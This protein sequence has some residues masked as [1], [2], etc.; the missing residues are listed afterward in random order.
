VNSGRKHRAEMVSAGRRTNPFRIR[1]LLLLMRFIQV[2]G[3]ESYYSAGEYEL[4][5]AEGDVGDVGGE[6][7]VLEAHFK[8]L[9]E[10]E[11][12]RGGC[13]RRLCEGLKYYVVGGIA[14][15]A[16]DNVELSCI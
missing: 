2:L 8:D 12:L 16:L 6:F 13:E 3:I 10:V 4:E 1:I 9:N 11:G 15:V 14:L 7:G 5:S